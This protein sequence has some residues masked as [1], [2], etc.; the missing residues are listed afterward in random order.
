MSNEMVKT[1]VREMDITLSTYLQQKE[2]EI[3]TALIST[4]YQVGKILADVKDKLEGTSFNFVEWVV[5]IGISPSCARNYVKYYEICERNQGKLEKFPQ[6][7]VLEFGK[8]DTPKELTEKVLNGEIKTAKQ[9]RQLKKELSSIK[10]ELN[11]LE[12]ENERLKKE[13][14]KLYK[15]YGSI[16][17]ANSELEMKLEQSENRNLSELHSLFIDI[18]SFIGERASKA[19]FYLSKLESETANKELKKG[20][21]EIEKTLSL[22]AGV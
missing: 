14:S 10:P 11:K 22:M 5:S 18:N 8:E 19:R 16:I 20:L 3:K 17:D 6:E 21:S 2:T 15:D 9:L 13:N 4:V 12:E 7:L 1:E